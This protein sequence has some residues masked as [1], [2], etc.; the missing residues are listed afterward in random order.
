LRIAY[1]TPFH[2]P[3][4]G[5]TAIFASQLA[6]SMPTFGHQVLVITASDKD[7]HYHM[8]KENLT[9]VRLSSIHD[10][11]HA[12]EL[13]FFR[14]H[15]TI[16]KTLRQFHPDVIHVFA[17]LQTG[18]SALIYAKHAH[19]P[20]LI[21][22]HASSSPAPSSLFRPVIE[23]LYWRYA[24][25]IIQ[26]YNAILVATQGMETQIARMTRCKTTTILAGEHSSLEIFAM[27][28]RI[29]HKILGESGTQKFSSR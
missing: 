28:E 6:E 25:R 21:T 9:I 2:V 22:V 8:Y 19:I 4:T 27:H 11:F 12:W 20:I 15:Q 18:M 7:H 29:Y 24:S 10:P 5:G 14:S 16:I 23:S 13:L 3:L 1:F 17:S 26:Q